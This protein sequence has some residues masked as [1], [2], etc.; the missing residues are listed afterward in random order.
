[1]KHNSEKV[2]QCTTQN[3]SKPTVCR[4][5]F[6]G[7]FLF[8]CSGLLAQAN[9]VG[10]NNSREDKSSLMDNPLDIPMLIETK[11]INIA[12]IPDPHQMS[13]DG[14]RTCHTKRGLRSGKSK[15]QVN[16]I[17][18][19]CHSSLSAHDYI[20][21]TDLRPSSNFKNNMDQMF[22]KQTRSK[23]GIVN[24]TVCHDMAIQCTQKRKHER[25]LNPML[26][27]GGPYTSRSDI[28]FRCHNKQAYQRL[29]PHDQIDRNGNIKQDKCA[30]CHKDVSKLTNAKSITDVDFIVEGKLEN[31]CT[32][33]HKVK[34]H[35]GGS[36]NFTF[37][38]REAKGPNHLV[39]P[40]P[41]VMNTIKQMSN[42]NGI[43]MPL[44]PQTNQVFCGTCHNPHQ[45]GVIKVN[46]SA[47]GADERFRLRKQDI[48]GQCHDF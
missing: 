14:C 11:S 33:C 9:A 4:N 28:C 1:M 13:K 29:N 23:G 6:Y 32:G 24:C 40:P 37:S 25:G 21:P 44:D 5:I 19:S 17:C 34:A 43:T 31:M 38:G 16:L 42:K 45:K 15:K 7:F 18:A 2:M 47:H 30:L 46:E 36:F 8:F 10:T 3:I 41:R 27:R 20:H 35:P 39:V 26:L 22:S 12:E 48:C